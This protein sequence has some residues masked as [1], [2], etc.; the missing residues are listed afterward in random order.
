MPNGDS[1]SQHM[2][3]LSLA[4][5]GYSFTCE[6][7]H[8]ASQ[9]VLIGMGSNIISTVQAESSEAKTHTSGNTLVKETPAAA[10]EV[11]HTKKA[12]QT[13]DEGA[14]LLDFIGAAGTK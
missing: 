6:L 7:Y 9:Q 5:L 3:V 12:S 13:V 2:Q 1:L 11:G 8:T 10:D 4:C 14:D